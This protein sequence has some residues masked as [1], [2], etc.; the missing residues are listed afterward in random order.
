M[1]DDNLQSIIKDAI[2]SGE[3]TIDRQTLLER[4]HRCPIFGIIMRYPALLGCC[5]KNVSKTAIVCYFHENDT[6]PLC[7][8]PAVLPTALNMA[9]KNI[10]QK[11]VDDKKF[12]FEE[13]EDTDAIGAL[14]A[15]VFSKNFDKEETAV[16]P[17]VQSISPQPY[18][19][20]RDARFDC[21]DGTRC[22]PNDCLIY[23]ILRRKYFDGHY[24]IDKIKRYCDNHFVDDIRLFYGDLFDHLYAF[25]REFREAWIAQ[26]TVAN[27]GSLFPLPSYMAA[28]IFANICNEYVPCAY[29]NTGLW[30]ICHEKQTIWPSLNHKIYYITDEHVEPL[31]LNLSKYDGR[32]LEL[33]NIPP[34]LSIFIENTVISRMRVLV[35]QMQ[36][37]EYNL[38]QLC[39]AVQHEIP[40]LA[41][42]IAYIMGDVV[43]F[44]PF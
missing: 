31:I 33:L 28:P 13:E 40:D 4:K 36:R 18:I 24:N 44:S 21:H 12:A 8:K 9:Y 38:M 37:C 3:I 2:S 14:K 5:N 34:N 23:I 29:L 11:M 43:P 30:K 22:H 17:V 16:V 27:Y 42:N 20:R 10:L 41:N 26:K 25:S 39:L 35:E 6:C 7:N 15:F 19:P 32:V 1:V